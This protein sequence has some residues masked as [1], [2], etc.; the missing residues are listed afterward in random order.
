MEWLPPVKLVVVSFP[1]PLES[2]VAAPSETAPSI[3][4]TL[5]VGSSDVTA[6]LTWAVNV[7]GPPAG[8][9]GRLEVSASAVASELFTVICACVWVGFTFPSPL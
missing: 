4:V 2:K 5:P 1:M 8:A 6:E 3:K 7:T 9:F